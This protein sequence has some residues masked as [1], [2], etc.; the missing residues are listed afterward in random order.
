MVSPQA[1][2]AAR[3]AYRAIFRATTVTFKGDEPLLRA[4]RQKTREAYVAN[5]SLADE[6]AYAGAVKHANDVAEVLLKNVA[7]AKQREDGSWNLRM[8]EHTELGDNETINRFA[9]SKMSRDRPRGTQM[10]AFSTFLPRQSYTRDKR[11]AHQKRELPVLKA[12][13]LEESFVRGSGPGG[14]AINK[15]S[16]CVSLIHRP[17][18]IRVLAQPTRSRQQNRKI[19]RKILLDKLDQLMNPGLSKTDMKR[20]KIRER[21]RQRDKKRRKEVGDAED[22]IEDDLK[23]PLRM[24]L[25]RDG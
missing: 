6:A 8:T 9:S 18:G 12:E 16:S 15:T 13:D 19:A 7:Q 11:E 3:A 23:N 2:A 24:G 20:D 10:R 21:K 14:Q 22:E 4:F 17:T 1:Q 25:P 5:R